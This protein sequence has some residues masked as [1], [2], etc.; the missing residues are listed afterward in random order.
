MIT[1][2]LQNGLTTCRKTV[3][4]RLQE[5]VPLPIRQRWLKVHFR[6]H[7]AGI[8]WIYALHKWAAFSNGA[9]RSGGPSFLTNNRDCQARW[10]LPTGNVHKVSVPPFFARG[11]L[12]EG[13][14][15]DI[16]ALLWVWIYALPLLTPSSNLY[17]KSVFLLR[18][19]EGHERK[20]RLII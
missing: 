17:Q 9:T 1:A 3:V 18:P 15:L 16:V 10:F 7:E 5:F 14:S 6:F 13:R 12:T 2:W 8:I 11:S 20:S 19:K 4:I